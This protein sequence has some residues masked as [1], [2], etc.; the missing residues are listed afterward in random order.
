MSE[1]YRSHS[2]TVPVMRNER[3]SGC[4]TVAPR[5]SWTLI[6]GSNSI[7]SERLQ[8]AERSIGTSAGAILPERTHGRDQRPET[9][10][11]GKLPHRLESY[12]AEAAALKV[13]RDRDQQRAEH[14]RSGLIQTTRRWPSAIPP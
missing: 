9:V 7:P 12:R 6:H 3:A 13:A 10:L 1:A 2:A 11:S 5:P 14:V 8:V 4:R